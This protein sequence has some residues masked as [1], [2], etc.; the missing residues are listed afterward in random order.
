[1]YRDLNDYELISYV[2][3]NNEEAKEIIFKKYEPLIH[4]R[5]RK[6]FKYCKNNGAEENDLV[7]EGM[8]GLNDAIKTF[9][10]SKDAIFYTYALKC[11]N[12]RIISYIVKLGRLKNKVLNDSLFLELNQQNESNS[13][14]KNLVDNSYNPEEILINEEKK[15]EILDIMDKTLTDF[16]KEVMDLKINGFKYKEIAD[17]LGKDIKYIDNCIQKCKNKIREELAKN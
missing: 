12:S 1:M 16:E 7:Q 15:Q 14:G 17:I 8:I 10:D 9:Q 3:E 5:A 4:D 13:F 2:S 11:I 6:L